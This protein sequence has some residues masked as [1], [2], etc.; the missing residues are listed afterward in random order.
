MEH[1]ISLEEVRIAVRKQGKNKAPGSDGI[2]LGFHEANWAT[3]Q[4]DIGAMINQM[5]KGEKSVRATVSRID[6]V[7]AQVK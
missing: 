7:P 5:F 1:H 6:L 2:G 4:D 3:I